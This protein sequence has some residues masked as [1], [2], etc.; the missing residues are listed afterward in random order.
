[1]KEGASKEELCLELDVCPNSL[2]RWEKKFPEFREAIKKGCDLSR[3]WWM[4]KGRDNLTN[5]KGFHAVLW[6]MNMKNRHGWKDKQDINVQ[7]PKPVILERISG[8][9]ESY[10]FTKELKH[11]EIE[12]IEAPE[13]P[14][15]QE[16]EYS[17]VK[18]D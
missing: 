1:M 8:E 3:A 6:Y 2:Y 18:S 14:E 12:K 4:K 16:A 5:P 13:A 15:A 11:D 7:L 17:I 10:G 9:K